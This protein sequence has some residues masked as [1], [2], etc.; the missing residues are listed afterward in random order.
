[1]TK[2]DIIEVIASR[3][4]ASR[5]ETALIVNEFIKSISR[6]L[7]EGRH[8]ELRKFGTFK[9]R[10]R[11]AR[12]ARNPR[13]GEAVSVPAKLVP[14]FKVSRELRNNVNTKLGGGTSTEGDG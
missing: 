2:A 1:M 11:R 3:R 13:S 6:A 9:V 14:H 10:E 5:T 7:C 8:I 4:G 12:V